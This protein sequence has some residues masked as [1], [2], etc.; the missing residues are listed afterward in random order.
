MATTT[1]NQPRTANGTTGDIIRQI[2]V[3]AGFLSVIIGNTL[4]EAVPINAQ[5]T[6]AISNR[7]PVLITPANYAFAIWGVIWLGLA[8]YAV[9]QALPAQRTNPTLRR[10]APWFLLS[11]AANVIWL[12]LFHYNQFWLSCVAIGLLTLSLAVIYVQLGVG[13]RVVST[14]ERLCTHL[15]FS[16]YLGWLCVATIVNIAYSLYDSGLR[17]ERG[18][19]EIIT[20]VMIVVVTGLGTIFAVRHKEIAL[21]AVFI[22]AFTAIANSKVNGVNSTVGMAALAMAGLLAVLTIIV[23]LAASRMQRPVVSGLRSVR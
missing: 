15:P 14:A 21:I 10:I 4:S 5:T 11:C 22:W 18:T 20:V 17:P 9:F 8:A 12:V 1:L 7:Y 16:L 6:G 3:V 2:A 19:Q 13:R 23:Q